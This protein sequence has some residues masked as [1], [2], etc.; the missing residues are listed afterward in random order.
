MKLISA[1]ILSLTFAAGAV[2]A[3][4]TPSIE[5][6]VDLTS[7]A[8]LVRVDDLDDG[9]VYSL[10]TGIE[11]TTWEGAEYTSVDTEW[12]DVGDIEDLVLDADGQLVAV[13]ADIGGFLGIA[14]RTVLLPVTD[15]RLVPGE[16][17]TFSYVTRL[18]QAEL[19]Q[20]PEVEEGF[21]D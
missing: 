6:T 15:V 21:W 10:E 5:T 2:M 4:E 18:S 1:S 17:K 14:E 13:I 19:E 16:D 3:Q 9:N 20:M 12:Q 8:G 11:A 7:A